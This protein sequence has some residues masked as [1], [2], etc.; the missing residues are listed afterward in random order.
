MRDIVR[1]EP[2]GEG[3]GR[4]TRTGTS[5]LSQDGEERMEYGGGAENTGLG[6]GG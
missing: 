5:V 4:G 3:L 6:L 2:G 1:Y